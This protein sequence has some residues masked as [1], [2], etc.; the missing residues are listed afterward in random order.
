MSKI[1]PTL[2]ATRL[3][4]GAEGAK[5]GTCL[6]RSRSVS[7]K[8]LAEIMVA[9]D[10]ISIFAAGFAAK[11]MYV[12][13]Q[14][15]AQLDTLNYLSIMSLVALGFHFI[16]R[17]R[18]LYDTARMTDF[19]SQL[20]SVL[21]V[22]LTTCASLF[23]VLF[24]LKISERFSRLWCLD[25]SFL[26]LLFLAVGRGGIIGYFQRMDRSGVLRRSVVLIGSGEQFSSLRA[27]ISDDNRN[28]SLCA[29]VELP[30]GPQMGL[31]EIRRAVASFAQSAHEI[32]ADDIMIALPPG[33]V[34]LAN[35]IL[36]EVQRVPADIH[37]VPDWG[38][39]PYPWIRLG[40][41]GELTYV[42]MTSKPISGWGAFFKKTED[43]LMAVIGLML[44]AP[45][46]AFIAAAIKL[47][48][49]GPIFF[50]QRRHGY[51]HKVIEVLKFRS[52]TCM[53]DGNQVVQATRG[54]W[55]VTRIGR[56]LRRTSLDELPQLINVLRG[57]MSIVGPRPHALAHNSHYGDLVENYANRH[58]VKP[59]ITGWAQVHG[60]RGETENPEKMAQRISYDLE[61][62]DNW[63]IWL[64]IKIILMTPL[65]GIFRKGAY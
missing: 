20:S 4:G 16:A 41:M 12:A 44:M 48:S 58:R 62:I 61:Y 51:N 64:D 14:G 40:H 27:Y 7:R 32:E 21:Y 26:L 9:F 5:T 6:N 23:M 52:M 39:L 53:D 55:R 43:Y 65:F 56:M 22:W 35:H 2:N 38:G 24:F 13:V 19:P 50:R 29:V 57:E 8:M 46:M 30:L 31:E 59:G 18:G 63:S 11:Y 3:Y 45:A 47:D 33:H 28:Y 34:S 10:S 1:L 36:Q 54:D 25:W 15:G 42:T 49:K 17:Q 60:F 37:I